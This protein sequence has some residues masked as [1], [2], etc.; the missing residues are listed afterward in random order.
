M[1]NH[2]HH[3]S[4]QTVWL[5]DLDNT[6]HNASHAI[7]PALND[8]MNIYMR[9]MFQ[10]QGIHK[11][12]EEVDALRRFYW[13]YY[14]A[15]LFGLAKHHHINIEHFLQETHHFTHI[16]HMIVAE[17]QVKHVLRTLPGYKVILTNGPR[18]YAKQVLTFL[19]IDRFFDAVISVE[20]MHVHRA[21]YPKPSRRFLTCL[22]AKHHWQPQQ[23]VL[24][25]DTLANLKAA[26]AEGLK[27]VWMT[28]FLKSNPRLG[29]VQ[30]KRL[31]AMRP[32]YV[33]KKIVSL[34]QLHHLFSL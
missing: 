26:K 20:S 23:C 1:Q 4:R 15:T 27:T 28:R 8:N 7:F 21:L 31:Q 11:T 5:F 18:A 6:L 14:G 17:K 13:R 16:E 3:S 10:Q 9:Q 19:G 32:S 34:R 2:Q 33:D 30:L 12:D 29:A 22:M 25:E 24:V